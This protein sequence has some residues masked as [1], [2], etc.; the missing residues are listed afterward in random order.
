M[1]ARARATLARPRATRRSLCS[2]AQ[3]IVTVVDG[4]PVLVQESVARESHA[5]FTGKRDDG[6]GGDLTGLRVWEAAP[7]MIRHLQRNS[8]T[9]L[10]NRSVLDLG[11][12][13]GA[14]G[15]A[16]AAIGDQTT[17]VL[18]DADSKASISSDHGWEEGSVLQVLQHNVELNAQSVRDAVTTAEL[19]WGHRPHIDTLLSRFPSGFDTIVASDTLYY[20][21]EETYD[22]L[23]A[24]I[25]ALAATNSRILLSYMVR[26][27]MEY[28]FID[29][30]TSGQSLGTPLSM[31]SGAEPPTF[32]VVGENAADGFSRSAA[33]HATRLVELRRIK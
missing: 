14:V 23:A 10:D 25:R 20:R 1:W 29:L 4:V 16:A 3:R 30:L 21:P 17:V 33:S 13:T 28:T 27:G 18:S 9:F 26:H 19:Q 5:A 7:V 2:T 24:T 6:S 15:L 12:G 31:G 32:E 8:E 11:C 22:D